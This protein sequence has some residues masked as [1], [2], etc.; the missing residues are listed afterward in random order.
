MSD[1]FTTKVAGVFVLVSMA[2]EFAALG[3]AF[4]H[5]SGPASMNGMN[6][7]VGEQLMTFQPSW[8]RMLFCLAV[9]SP[10]LSMLAWP[11]MYHILAPG[12]SSAFFGVIVSSL[13]ML[14]GVVAE[15]IRLSMVLTLPSAYV[16]AS[17]AAKPSILILGAFL[18]SAVSDSRSD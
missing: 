15:A 9:L 11:G 14:L 13:A 7:G 16:A 17:D 10:C 8:M 6:W 1:T 12:G 18:G 2:V 4:S 5:G 3:F